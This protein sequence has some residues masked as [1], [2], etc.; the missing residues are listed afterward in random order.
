MADP[1]RDSSTKTPE[2]F[3][4]PGQYDENGVEFIVVGGQL[5]VR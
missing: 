1:H 2:P 3:G 5:G 4:V